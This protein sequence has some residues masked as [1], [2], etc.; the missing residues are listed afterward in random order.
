M[1]EANWDGAFNLVDLGGRPLSDGSRTASG[2]YFRSGASEYLTNAG[3]RQAIA[4]GL[5]TVIDLRNEQEIVREQY[6][7]VLD[8][9]ALGDIAV[10]NLPTED[11]TDEE[12]RRVCGPWLDH[13]RSYA[14]NLRFYPEKFARIFRQL[15]AADGAVLFHCAGGRDRTGMI[16]AILLRLAAVAPGVIADDYE[17]GFRAAHERLK[18]FPERSRERA[19]PAEE[20][21]VRI[22]ERRASLVAWIGR[23]DA[24]AYLDGL[25][26]SP[27]TIDNLAARL[28][29]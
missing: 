1:S 17:R 29:R 24:R 21:D 18:R 6:H 7:P 10:V 12:F 27:T 16:A 11:P 19:H 15:S 25:G 28:T 26:L 9:D 23:F 20:F 14:D 4:A 22:V 8:P 13:P 2:R 3:W 5:T